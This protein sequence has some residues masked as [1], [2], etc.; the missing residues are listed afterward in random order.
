MGALTRYP[1]AD[2]TGVI[3]VSIAHEVDIMQI[4]IS[5]NK[6]I[7]V[8][9]DVF[10]MTV[11][12]DIDITVYV[13]IPTRDRK[14]PIDAYL[15]GL[16]ILSEIYVPSVEVNSAVDVDVRYGDAIT[17]MTQS[18]SNNNRCSLTYDTRTSC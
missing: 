1:P 6:H 16:F 12:V 15:P 7:A 11:T 9:L 10:Q 18:L 3:D 17:S 2:T 14:I 4:K 13:P 5:I 8:Y